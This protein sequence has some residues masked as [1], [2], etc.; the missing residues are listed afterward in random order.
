MNP[1]L[2]LD[3][4][5]IALIMGLYLLSCPFEALA[6]TFVIETADGSAN[7]VGLDTS[8]GL[9]AQGNPHVSYQG[10][11]PFQPMYARKSS[12]VW[13]TEIRDGLPDN[14]G[15]YTSLALDTQGNPHVSYFDFTTGDLKY[16]SAAVDLASPAGGVTWAVGSRQE[17]VWTGLGPLAIAL[18]TDGTN[19]DNI[20]ATGIISSPFSIRVPRATSE[21]FSDTVRLVLLR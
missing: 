15:L 18:A 8:L 16:A 1:A 7:S 13:T 11:P 2:P 19:F 9:D 3:R 20:L 10:G 5:L 6:Q 4:V 12:G 14:Q 17:I 21:N